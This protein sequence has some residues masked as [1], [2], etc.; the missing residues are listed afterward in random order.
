MIP[1]GPVPKWT[2]SRSRSDYKVCRSTDIL[3]QRVHLPNQEEFYHSRWCWGCISAWQGIVWFIWSSSFWLTPS[4]LQVNPPAPF[5]FRSAVCHTSTSSTFLLSWFLVLFPYR[6]FLWNKVHYRSASAPQ[7]C[8]QMSGFWISKVR[9]TDVHQ[10]KELLPTSDCTNCNSELFAYL[11][12][13]AAEKQSAL[14]IIY[15]NAQYGNL[16]TTEL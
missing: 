9:R 7:G 1:D 8:N 3:S 11:K 14:R 16:S 15:C 5:S 2:G 4:I 10:N 12:E 6:K 13:K